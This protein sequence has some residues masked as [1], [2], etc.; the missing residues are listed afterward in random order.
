MK[1]THFTRKNLIALA[2]SYFHDEIS[3]VFLTPVY[4]QSYFFIIPKTPAFY[5]P[6]FKVTLLFFSE[7]AGSFSSC[8]NSIDHRR[9]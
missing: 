9:A 3:S 2:L 1:K 6:G 5:K 4:T 8:M 7:F